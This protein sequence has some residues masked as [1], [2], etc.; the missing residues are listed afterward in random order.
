MPDKL[1]ES[2]CVI[3]LALGALIWVWVGEWKYFVSALIL[4]FA[5]A[6]I[7]KKSAKSNDRSG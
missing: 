4:V 6:A 2:V 7:A 1:A 3:L 5:V